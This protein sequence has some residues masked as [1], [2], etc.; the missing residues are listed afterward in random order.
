LARKKARHL[1]GP[2]LLLQIGLLLVVAVM[3]LVMTNGGIRGYNRTGYNSEC[4][5]SEQ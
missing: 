5:G 2:I 1:A 3:R 4:N